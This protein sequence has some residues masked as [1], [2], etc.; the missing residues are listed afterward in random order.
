M[1][2]T[3]VVANSMKIGFLAFPMNFL[4][5]T[6]QEHHRIEMNFVFHGRLYDENHSNSVEFLK[7]I[8]F[9]TKPK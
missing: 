1:D 5:S 6:N 9:L 8:E 3:F 4:R 2:F 7:L